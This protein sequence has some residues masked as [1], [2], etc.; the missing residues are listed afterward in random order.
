MPEEHFQIAVINGVGVLRRAGIDKFF[1]FAFQTQ[2]IY[3]HLHIVWN[4][5]R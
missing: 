5:T 3:V 1:E 4:L 2:A